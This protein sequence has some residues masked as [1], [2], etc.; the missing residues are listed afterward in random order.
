MKQINGIRINHLDFVPVYL[1]DLIYQEGPIL[2]HFSN[3]ENPT[4]HYLYRWTDTDDSCNRWMVIKV[5]EKQLFELLTRQLS[6]Y[7]LV[8]SSPFSCFLDLDNTLQIKQI[9]LIP[10]SEIPAEYLPAQD[11]YLDDNQV[12]PYAIETRN[13]LRYKIPF[14]LAVQRALAELL[15]AYEKVETAV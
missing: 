6:L 14:D 3:K 10:V 1:G 9:Y 5:T 11:S 13:K 15:Q 7:K 2:S 12:E 8:H 4:E